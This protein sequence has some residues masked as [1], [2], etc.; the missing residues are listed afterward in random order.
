MIQSIK[1][2][3]DHFTKEGAIFCYR[4]SPPNLNYWL[5]EWNQSA[6][7]VDVEAAPLREGKLPPSDSLAWLEKPE[8][9]ADIQDRDIVRNTSYMPRHPKSEV[10]MVEVLNF[11]SIKVGFVRG[12][13]HFYHAHPRIVALRSM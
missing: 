13:L 8:G 2:S 10:R 6:D 12:G 9:S 5:P 11:L 4:P 7:A 3:F 1:Q